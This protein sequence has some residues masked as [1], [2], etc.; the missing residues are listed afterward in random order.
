[1]IG[2]TPVIVPRSMPRVVVLV[3]AQPEP[4][5]YKSSPQAEP[6]I[7]GTL[8]LPEMYAAAVVEAREVVKK[9]FAPSVRSL[10]LIFREEVAISTH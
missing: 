2:R 3:V 1:M 4:F 8:E 9:R 7:W 6:L 5:Q 10:V